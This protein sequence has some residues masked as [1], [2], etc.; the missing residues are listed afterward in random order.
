MRNYIIPLLGEE[1]TQEAKSHSET[2]ETQ[3]ASE[4]QLLEQQINDLLQEL[5]QDTQDEYCIFKKNVTLS[6]KNTFF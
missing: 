5:N 6:L 1:Q 2:T 3:S 4:K